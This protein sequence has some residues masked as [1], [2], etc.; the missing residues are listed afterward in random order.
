MPLDVSLDLGPA[1]I[2]L[3]ISA[4]DEAGIIRDKKSDDGR[5]RLG[6][7]NLAKWGL[8]RQEC[9]H[10]FG[11]EACRLG[12]AGCPDRTGAYDV[13]PDLAMFKCPFW[14]GPSTCQSAQRQDSGGCVEES[15][16]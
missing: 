11:I 6:F 9:E 1:T 10:L 8:R 13:D 2:R 14:I 12:E 3:D 5:D 15:F 16:G 4:I 7:P